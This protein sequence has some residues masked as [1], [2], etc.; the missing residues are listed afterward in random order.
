[1]L[2]AE[3]AQWVRSKPRASPVPAAS[4]ALSSPQ[5]VPAQMPQSPAS[6][7]VSAVSPP[8]AQKVQLRFAI[9]FPGLRVSQERI[10][11]P[12]PEPSQSLVWALVLAELPPVQLLSAL[13]ALPQL[14]LGAVATKSQGVLPPARQ[15]PVPRPSPSG[16]VVLRGIRR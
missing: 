15:P 16:E 10:L 4:L 2:E 6:A 14:Q 1:V 3:A 7:Q 11:V 13:L 5:Q 8:A 12:L 9:P